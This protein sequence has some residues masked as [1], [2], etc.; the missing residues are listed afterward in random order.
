MN[1]LDSLILWTGDRTKSGLGQRLSAR[2]ARRHEMIVQSY[3]FSNHL[4]I[5]TRASSGKLHLVKVRDE[6]QNE[7][8]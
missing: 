3:L 2:D 5:T 8:Q 4:I 7:R 6:K 1:Y